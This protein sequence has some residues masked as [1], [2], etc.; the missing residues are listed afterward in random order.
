MSIFHLHFKHYE[1]Y[2]LSNH[3][4]SGTNYSISFIMGYQNIVMS[5]NQPVSLSYTNVSNF[6]T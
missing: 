3:D 6:H 5:K 1:Y 4:V 2:N